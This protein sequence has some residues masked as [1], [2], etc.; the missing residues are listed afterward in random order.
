MQLPGHGA[1]QGTLVEQHGDD[2]SVM[3]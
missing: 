2:I 3:Y 1:E